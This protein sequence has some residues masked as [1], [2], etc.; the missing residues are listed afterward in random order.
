MIFTLVWSGIDVGV[1]LF[2]ETARQVDKSL[3]DVLAKTSHA[4]KKAQASAIPNSCNP[5]TSSIAPK[6]LQPNHDWYRYQNII[7]LYT[8]FK[9]QTCQTARPHG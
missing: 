5:I 8:R 1:V 2:E 9:I 6:L 7:G 4:V 3:V